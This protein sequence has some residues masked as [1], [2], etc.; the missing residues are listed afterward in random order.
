MKEMFALIDTHSQWDKEATTKPATREKP[1][2][3]TD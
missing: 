3:E 1:P 2:G